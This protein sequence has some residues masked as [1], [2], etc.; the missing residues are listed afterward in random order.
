MKMR[1]MLPLLLVLT[2][3]FAFVACNRKNPSLTDIHTSTTQSEN[4]GISNVTSGESIESNPTVDSSSKN[5]TVSKPT[6]SKNEISS[7]NPITI[8][9]KTALKENAYYCFAYKNTADKTESIIQ[10]YKFYNSQVEEQV[11][12]SVQ[13]DKDLPIVYKGQ[14]Y[15]FVASN[16]MQYNLTD[17]EIVVKP[18]QSDIEESP[19]LANMEFRFTIN[20]SYNLVVSHVPFEDSEI[21]K[22]DIL[23]LNESSQEISFKKITNYFWKCGE[24][25]FNENSGSAPP[26]QLNLH[27]FDFSNSKYVNANCFSFQEPTTISNVDEYVKSNPGNWETYLFENQLFIMAASSGCE[28]AYK[29]KSTDKTVEIFFAEADGG[30]KIVFEK[31]QYNTLMVI[32]NTTKYSI[33]VETEFTSYPR[34]E[35]L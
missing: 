26:Y 3:A 27:I 35:K 20:S 32:S 17:K 7:N 19:E 21:N 25:E 10:R 9:P 18:L 30:G 12:S 11:F 2:F 1:K 33:P 5:E 23:I 6:T 34:W 4:D 14:T 8:N 13:G 31:K 29:I 24:L 22:G 16:T 28:E 15:Y